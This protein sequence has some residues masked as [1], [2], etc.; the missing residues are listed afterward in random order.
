MYTVNNKRLAPIIL[1]IKDTYA[2]LLPGYNLGVTEDEIAEIKTNPTTKYFLELGD[3]EYKKVEE[4]VVR[5]VE[6]IPVA[7]KED[8]N[9]DP[10][11]VTVTKKVATP[12]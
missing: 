9:G 10:V 3:L 7:A 11:P 6:D 12:R 8:E 5:T 1:T 4:E 2:T